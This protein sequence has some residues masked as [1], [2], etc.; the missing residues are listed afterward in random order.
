LSGLSRRSSFAEPAPAKV[1]VRDKRGHDVERVILPESGLTSTGGMALR[2]QFCVDAAVRTGTR[3][4][5]IILRHI[6][7]D[8]S[9]R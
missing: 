3:G 6:L 7:P 2:D 8:C 9:P 4:S 1:D 5:M